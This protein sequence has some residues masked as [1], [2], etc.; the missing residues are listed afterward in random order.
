[1]A[2]GAFD[3]NTRLWRVPEG[4]LFDPPMHTWHQVLDVAF[5]PDGRTL[6]L[7]TVGGNLHLWHVAETEEE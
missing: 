4:E 5:S 6:A 1:L 7:G 3:R 2:S